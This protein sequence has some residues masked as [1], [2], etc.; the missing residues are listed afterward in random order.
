[1]VH[2][3]AYLEQEL[4]TG[5]GD[6]SPNSMDPLSAIGL[7][8]TAIK[9]TSSCLKACH[10]GPSKHRQD[11]LQSISK[12]LWDFNGSLKNL[13]T[14]YDI[15][16]EDQARSTLLPSIEDHLSTCNM[17]L[18][19]IQKHLESKKSIKRFFKGARSDTILEKHLICLK[20]SRDLFNEALQAD[21]MYHT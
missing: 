15:Y 7:V 1:M 16:E 12:Q 6:R 20:N 11:F 19:A 10:I 4:V 2:V 14:H 3:I 17:A 5:H 13:E 18:E 21:Q 9:L 8:G